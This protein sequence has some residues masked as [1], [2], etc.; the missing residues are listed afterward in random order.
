MLKIAYFARMKTNFLM[1]NT[2]LWTDVQML[3]PDSDVEGSQRPGRNLHLENL[4]RVQKTAFGLVSLRAKT[5]TFRKVRVRSR[6][7]IYISVINMRVL[8]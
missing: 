2:F 1:L 8:F 7:Q 5:K 6:I 3:D 4:F